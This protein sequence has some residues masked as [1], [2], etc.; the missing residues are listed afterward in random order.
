MHF[1][2]LI[3]QVT[4]NPAVA[5]CPS[6][7]RVNPPDSRFCAGCGT[8]LA[9]TCPA[10][11]AEQEPDARFCNQCGA[12]LTADA[13]APEPRAPVSEPVGTER[14]ICSVLFA[15]LVGFTPLS[16]T[17]DPEEVRELLSRYFEVARTI[18]NRYG[19]T[20]EK[21]IGDAVM[22]VWGTPVA[23]EGDAERAV[24]AALEVVDAVA[25]L[26]EEIGVTGLA[27]RAGVVTGEVAATLGAVGQGMVA[28]DAVNT[29]ARVQAAAASGS[30][31]VDVTTRR[32]ASAAVGFDDAG[33]HSLKGK[34][35]PEPLW[36]ATRVLSTVGGVQRV[37]GLE[38]PLIGRDAELRTIKEMFHASADRQAARMVVVVGPA[39]VGKSRLG[40]EFEKYID[41]LKQVVS[42]HRG[43]CLSYGDG[44][45]FWALSEAVRQRLGIAEEDPT[46]VAAQKLSD[47][48]AK[49]VT[50]PDERT[51]VSVRLGR[52]LGLPVEDDAGVPLDR[53]ELFAGWRTFIERL[54]SDGPVVWVIEDAQYAD[55]G[56]LEFCD[57]LID[58]SRNLPIFLLVL[59][60]PEL[61]QRRSGFGVGRN[62]G[63]L[64]LDPLDAGSMER[65]VES[66]VPGIPSAA[67][68]AI[69]DHS[70]GV[71]LFAVETV[72]SLIDRDVVVPVEGAYRLV[73]DV[74]VLSVPDSLHAL[75]ASR[76][77]AL[78]PAVR[79][80]TADAAVLGTSFPAEA[81]IAI[82][83]QA[84]AAVR[85]GL[86]DLLR[87]EVF[88]V[89]ADPLSPQRGS[90]RFAQQ[91]LRQVAY[92]TLSRRD[93]KSRHLAVAT[94]LRSTFAD[95]GEEVADVVARHY[96][97]ALAAVP[98]DPDT[99]Q[100]SREV[101]A[102][103]V[104]AAERA[105]RA[106]A[107]ATAAT[108]YATAAELAEQ[109]G[110]AEAAM[111]WEEAAQSVERT[112][113]FDLEVRYADHARELHEAAGDRRSAARAQALGGRAMRRAG[114]YT[115]AR[116]LLEAAVGVLRSEPDSD[117]VNVMAQLGALEVFAG[118][119]NAIQL[120]ADALELGQALEVDD[121]LLAGLLV[122]NGLAHG[123][124]N[125]RTESAA[126][127][128]EAARIGERSGNSSRH[129]IALLN[130]ADILAG[131]DLVAA[132]EAARGSIEL[133]RRIGDRNSMS[134]SVFNLV[135]VLLTA[136]RWD[137]AQAVTAGL[138]DDLGDQD[139]VPV[140]VGLLAG[141]RGDAPTAVAMLDGLDQMRASEDPQEVTTWDLLAAVA[142]QAAG[143]TA[144]ALSHSRT[145]LGY[146]DAVGLR[147]E[148]VRWAWPIAA[149]AADTLGDRGAV[150][151]LI[152]MLESRPVGHVPLILRA[153]LDLARA[154]IA[155][156][157]ASEAA[158]PVFDRAL[159]GLRRIP[160]PYHL[161]HALVDRAEYLTA[162][163][164]PDRAARDLEEAAGIA[165]RLGAEPLA[166]RTRQM[167]P[168]AP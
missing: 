50:D 18:V 99:E 157:D 167:Q 72:R 39:G 13:A 1:V 6:C 15:D 25:A 91:L 64:A 2:A 26:G 34:A 149:R 54:A 86:A 107:P 43:R 108:N 113:D 114:R 68:D 77:D 90:Y 79:S 22:A 7:A 58:W 110:L 165:T 29:A 105:R 35:E 119:P 61:E 156:S 36:R 10:C 158:G 56:L 33:H 133:L 3:A 38:A 166:R 117:T 80:L 111:W 60:R 62:R 112:A 121:D 46:E 124:A 47:G 131:F 69:T 52:L 143:D 125:R 4:D 28:G 75:L 48:L 144:G 155:A 129:G 45:A 106:G 152:E 163:G 116:Q 57:H 59:A 123:I 55:G 130:L 31:L 41:G 95:D 42:W 70:Q 135:E 30:V 71:P 49:F 168:L 146:I 76:L 9:S 83:D 92:D 65:L 153:E 51:Y 162:V 24:R 88:E 21:F 161:G 37:D 74:G 134:A 100:I 132:E 32:L 98:D 127:L 97:D 27:A 160:A 140:S 103:S 101:I 145:V 82:S 44:V 109:A 93:R 85:A 142:A 53:E 115:E 94:H 89:S 136:G 151:E 20:V 104:R 66:L 120:A 87:R 67:R 147:V 118:S 141:L 81:L 126:Y 16:E 12:T 96:L 23:T 122:T 84:E 14:R 137:E 63:L 11:G 19:G 164:E 148:T 102:L 150:D 40:W 139:L 17:R 159:A 5:A 73:G 128:H 78:D 154:R 8:R 138:L